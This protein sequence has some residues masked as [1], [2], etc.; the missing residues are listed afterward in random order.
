MKTTVITVAAPKGGGKTATVEIILKALGFNTMLTPAKADQL[1]GNRLSLMLR[2]YNMAG[3]SIL[4]KDSYTFA[5]NFDSITFDPKDI[6]KALREA[7]IDASMTI[8]K[9]KNIK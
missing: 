9:T 1:G 4:Y 5:L 3:I 7:D 2:L 8:I 6:I